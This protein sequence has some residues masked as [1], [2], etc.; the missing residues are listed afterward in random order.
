MNVQRKKDVLRSNN[1]LVFNGRIWLLFNSG[2][3][4]I[5]DR[6]R[7]NWSQLYSCVW[8]V[9]NYLAKKTK[10]SMMKDILRSFTLPILSF[11]V[12]TVVVT[13]NL[14]LIWAV[15]AT[16]RR[17]LWEVQCSLLILLRVGSLSIGISKVKIIGKQS[18]KRRSTKSPDHEKVRLTSN[19]FLAWQTCVG[20]PVIVT[21]VRR[22]WLPVLSCDKLLLLFIVGNWIVVWVYCSIAAIHISFDCWRVCK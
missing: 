11:R 15:C 7:N 22:P 12:R 14:S 16:K 13:F 8:T 5:I 19:N 1:P 17:F 10:R 18:Y 20:E 4:R 21:D 3:P 6:A 9:T 2:T